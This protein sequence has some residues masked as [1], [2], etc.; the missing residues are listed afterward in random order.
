M[1]YKGY[2]KFNLNAS[3][4]H[5]RVG[6]ILKE[7]FPGLFIAQEV[8]IKVDK[9]LNRKTLYL[10]WY[11]PNLKIGFEV[12]GEFHYKENTMLEKD[13]RTAAF[14]R[15]KMNDRLKEFAANE[16]EIYLIRVPYWEIK[17]KNALKSYIIDKLSD[18]DR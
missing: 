15:I 11:I 16:E 7:L 9:G 2:N 6:E 5:R 13:Q 8:P 18:R 10:D 3:E 12:D 4:Y 17:D 1:R 14:E